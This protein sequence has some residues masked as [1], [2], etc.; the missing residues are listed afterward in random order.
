M[1]FTIEG[2]RDTP[3]MNT[4]AGKIPGQRI[5]CTACGT[6]V[7]ELFYGLERRNKAEFV[8]SNRKPSRN[9]YH[10]FKWKNGPVNSGYV[11]QGLQAGWRGCYCVTSRTSALIKRAFYTKGEQWKTIYVWIY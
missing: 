6:D 2:K 7:D 5:D 1:Q 8:I 4:W 3:R 9:D 10:T 11:D